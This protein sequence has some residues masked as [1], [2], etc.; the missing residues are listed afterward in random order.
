MLSPLKPETGTKI[1]SFSGSYPQP[2]IKGFKDVI[3]S[4]YLSLLHLTLD[5]SILFTAINSLWIPKLFANCTCSLVYPSRS[6]P[7]SNSPF[8]AEI[9]KQPKSASAAPIIILGT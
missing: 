5:S 4:V 8:L 6:N 2:E 7:D 3:I 9:T 1:Q